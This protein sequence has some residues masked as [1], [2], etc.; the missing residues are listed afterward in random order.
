MNAI[1][2]RN[3]HF[4][5]S[6]IQR[7]VWLY[8]RFNLSLRDVEELMAK[9]GVEVSYETIRRWVKR[10]G[11][12][13]ARRLRSGRPRAHPHWHL[14]E[15]YVSIGGRWMYLWRAID[16]DGEVLDYLVSAKRDKK[17]ALKLMRKLL[18]KYGFAPRTIV[19][20]NWRAYATAFRELGLTAWHHWAKW[21]NSRIEGSRVRI[22]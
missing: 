18:K 5:P 16:Q 2:Y 19:T 8:A 15:M 20:D 14:D 22:Q 4:P 11:P 1:S 6:I 10:F 17:A 3:L 13:I 21:K 12:Q 7:A 9:R